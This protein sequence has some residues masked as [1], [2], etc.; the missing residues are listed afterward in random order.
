MAYQHE[1]KYRW[2]Y[3][4]APY[5]HQISLL[6]YLWWFP[7]RNYPKNRR[8]CRMHGYDADITHSCTG[9]LE[10][11]LKAN[12]LQEIYA[13]EWLNYT[14]RYYF[15]CLLCW[16]FMKVFCKLTMKGWKGKWA[17]MRGER[18]ITSAASRGFSLSGNSRHSTR[19]VSALQ[20]SHLTFLNKSH[21]SC[22]VTSHYRAITLSWRFTPSDVSMS[23]N[24]I[25]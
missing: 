18:F 25:S 10:E 21:N 19:K 23:F 6:C 12:D 1:I 14:W 11:C 16:W 22:F 7:S 9:N 8:T 13:D 20:N 4:V 2:S 15:L 5:T 17:A 24:L 3:I